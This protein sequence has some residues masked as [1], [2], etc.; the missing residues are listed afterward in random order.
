MSGGKGDAEKARYWQRTMG[1]AAR[2]GMSIREFCRQRRLKESQFYWWQH[3]LSPRPPSR[4]ERKRQAGGHAGA[5]SFALV[6]GDAG[7]TDAGIEPGG[8]SY[9]LHLVE[10]ENLDPLQRGRRSGDRQQ[11]RRSRRAGLR[12]TRW[13]VRTGCFTAATKVEGRPPCSPVWWPPANGF[14]STPL[15]TCVTS[16]A[17]SPPTPRPHRRVAPGSN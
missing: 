17:A 11:R 14:V 16:S 9:R 15:P 13:G 2:S 3:K 5:A 7:M 6:S 10:R 4:Q 12:E 1:E 8:A